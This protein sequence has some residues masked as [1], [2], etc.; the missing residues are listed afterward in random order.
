MNSKQLYLRLLAYVK[1]YW[2]GFAVSILAMIILAAVQPLFPALLKPLMDESFVAKN[3]ESIRTMPILFILL[4]FV[5]GI[6]TFAGDVSITW[7][8]SRLIMDIRRDMFERILQLP[9]PY[10]DTHASGNLISKV[11]FNVSQVTT[12]CTNALVILIRDSLTIIFLLG[13]MFYLDWKLSLIVFVLVPVAALVIRLIAGRL[14]KLSRSLQDNIGD[15]THT[16]DEAITG[17]KVVRIFGGE[18]YE[19][20][21]F[22]HIN[23]WVRRNTMKIK[24]AAALNAP[25]VEFIAAF[26]LAVIVYVASVKSA[27]NQITVGGFVAFFTAMAMLFAPAKRITSINEQLQRALAAA[28]TVFDLIDQPV[29]KDEGTKVLER[30]RGHLVLDQ[31]RFHYPGSDIPALSGVSLEIQPGETIALVGQSGSGKSTI[32]NLIP[33]FYD[34][35]QGR[36]TL[37]Q[38][39]LHELK[40][41]NLRDHIALVSQEVVLF[42]D[43]IAA[44]IAYGTRSNASEAEIIQAAKAAHAWEFIEKLPDGLQTRVG[45]NGARL[46]G[47]QRQRIAIARAFLKDAPILL[48]DEATSALD[49][50]SERF[51]QDAM[52]KLRRD[53]TTIIIAH[54]LSTIQNA[55]RIIVMQDG[56]IVEA[57][58]HAEL[59][60]RNG[61]Y[62]KLCNMQ[63]SETQV[64]S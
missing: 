7:V 31:V 22:A 27:Q 1:P 35:Y 39:E 64:G 45:E 51:V 21:R 62:R 54:R 15:M 8:S 23:N 36:I 56:G 55:D 52:D 4:F 59:L 26:A 46:S 20:G 37:D 3:A 30:V 40:L 50:E 61:L 16:L 5:R 48:F 60:A 43:T 47:G 10:F 17:N 57:G 44:N 33:R 6:A 41:K 18:Q 9:R 34:T 38:V 58:K 25:V 11:T 24:T 12:A 2:K 19:T 13:L 49:T 53:R 28:E 29:E 14:R 32:V 42:D 63:F